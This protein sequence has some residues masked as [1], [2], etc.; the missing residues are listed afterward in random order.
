MIY[1]ISKEEEAESHEQ[2][3]DQSR[4]KHEDV[5]VFNALGFEDLA[6]DESK[7]GG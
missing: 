5:G 2:I 6:K 7:E 3:W 1:K 4:E